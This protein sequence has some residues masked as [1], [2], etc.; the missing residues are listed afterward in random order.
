VVLEL[1]AALVSTVAVLHRDRQIRRATRPSTV[2]SGSIPLLKKK[3]RFA[4]IVDVHPA[5]QIALTYVKPLD[6]VKASWLIGLA[7]ASAM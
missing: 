6:S 2:Y 3:L 7:P 1:L 4:R 5:R